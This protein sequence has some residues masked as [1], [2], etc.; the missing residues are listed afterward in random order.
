MGASANYADPFAAAVAAGG[1]MYDVVM[2]RVDLTDGS[3]TL[4]DPDS[5]VQSVGYAGGVN[6]ITFNAIGVGSTDYDPTQGTNF[7]GPR[8]S[9]L[10]EI[11]GNAVST[12]DLIQFLSLLKNAFPDP[13]DFNGAF[14][15]GVCTDPTSTNISLATG[16]GTVGG[17]CQYNTTGADTYGALC[18]NAVTGGSTASPVRSLITTQFG[19]DGGAGGVYTLL[20]GSDLRTNSGT[21]TA[22]LAAGPSGSVYVVVCAGTRGAVT[23]ASGN[24][25]KITADYLTLKA[26]L[27]A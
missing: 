22:T 7:K 5:L 24:Q 14:A 6:T 13:R 25:M 18:Y 21:R 27:P 9:K 23:V 20:D 26:A 4:L 11:D 17:A 16:M 1:S 2:N 8:W 10:L 12:A 19:G 15:L 3:W